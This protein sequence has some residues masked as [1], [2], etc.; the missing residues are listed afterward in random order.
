MKSTLLQVLVGSAVALGVTLAVQPGQA[1]PTTEQ[2]TC[3]EAANVRPIETTV[4]RSHPVRTT[5]ETVET[6]APVSCPSEAE[7]APVHPVVIEHPPEIHPVM[8]YFYCDRSHGN[9]TTVFQ[10]P[11]SAVPV[12]RWVSHYF[13]GSG[14]DPLTRCNDVSGRF[15]RF[16]E[17]GLL[18]FITTGIVNRQPVVCVTDTNGGPCLGVLF[19]L[20]PGQDA[21][22]TIQQLFD[23]SYGAA[24]PLYESGTR[25]YLDVNQYLQSQL[26][27]AN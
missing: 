9:P 19:T 5:V 15:Q 7:H 14:Y 21:S 10:A 18:N 13:A 1:C 24:G 23:I 4:E 25:V 2:P 8:G 3:E 11:D 16:Y 27:Q 17:S 26:S 22:R 6:C 12:I 20:K